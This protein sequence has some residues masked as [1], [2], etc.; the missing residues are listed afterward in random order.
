MHNSGLR[1]SLSTQN[2]QKS[3]LKKGRLSAWEY[4]GPTRSAWKERELRILSRTSTI[5]TARVL[6]VTVVEVCDYELLTMLHGVCGYYIRIPDRATSRSN[7]L[8]V[9]EAS[10][11][12]ILVHV[13]FSSP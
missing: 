12:K 3:Q 13:S 2:P 7:S 4:C 11:G 1:Y 8:V 6:H 5:P 9:F 10:T